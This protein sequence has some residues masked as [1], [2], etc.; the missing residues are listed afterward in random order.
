MRRRPPADDARPATSPRLAAIR[1]LGRRDYTAH[2]L[3][4]KLTDRGYPAAEIDETLRQL[5]AE[6]LQS[7][8]RAAA[9]FVQSASRNRRRGR[10]RIARELAARGVDRALVQRLTGQLGAEDDAAAI[11]AVLTRK[12]WPA[13]PTL[14]Q[15][16]RMFQH[17]L[18][19]GF[20]ADAIATALRHREDD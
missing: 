5:A 4:T 15:R 19:R 17:L 6:G 1:L 9:A 12:R 11:A 2:E 8:E 18:R 7:D 10:L 16:R 20:S 3:R 14:V 13:A